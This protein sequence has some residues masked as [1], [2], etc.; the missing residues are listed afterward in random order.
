MSNEKS[1]FQNENHWQ[2]LV[3]L[4]KEIAAEKGITQ[5]EIAERTGFSQGNIARVF[6]LKY[7]PSL[8]TF[9]AI[10]QALGVNFY[11]EDKEGTGNLNKAF[12][13]AID[14]LGRRPDKLPKN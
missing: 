12:E 7:G 6:S 4:L 14:A 10:A 2:V 9:I 8:K 5:Q 3:L 1:S 11:F 13:R